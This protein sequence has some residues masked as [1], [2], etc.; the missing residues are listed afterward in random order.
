V[1]VYVGVCV[2]FCVFLCLCVY[3][4][5]CACVCVCVCVCVCM[6]VCVC[7]C[8]CVCSLSYP[9]KKHTF[10]IILST[11]AC[12]AVPYFST[13]FRKRRNIRDNVSESTSFDFL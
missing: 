11:V 1:F 4:C 10:P 6:C 7:V 13:V 8:V 3:V 12:L 2:F 5:L 9:N